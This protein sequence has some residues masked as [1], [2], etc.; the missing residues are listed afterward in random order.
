M[1]HFSNPDRKGGTHVI[2]CVSLCAKGAVQ[3]GY[4]MIEY[5]KISNGIGAQ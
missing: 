5:T 4:S 2:N 1:E 3:T